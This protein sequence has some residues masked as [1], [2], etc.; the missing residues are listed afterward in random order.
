MGGGKSFKRNAILY[1]ILVLVCFLKITSMYPF[2]LVFAALTA[3]NAYMAYKHRNDK[4][5]PLVAQMKKKHDEKK[6]EQRDKKEMEKQ[7]KTDYKNRLNA[8]DEEFDDF[9][10]GDEEETEEYEEDGEEYEESSE[11]IQKDIAP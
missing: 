2:A 1:G 7:R 9:D 8:I 11:I 3:F 10:Y 4:P 6:T 5:H